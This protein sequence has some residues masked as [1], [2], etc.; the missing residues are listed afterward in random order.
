[1]SRTTKNLADARQLYSE[2]MAAHSK[3]G[4]PRLQRIFEAV[5]REAF[6]PPGPWHIVVNGKSVQTPSD[7]PALLYQNVLVA[8]DRN[9]GINNGE[10]FLHAAWLGAVAPASGDIVTHIGAGTGYYSAILAM[11]VLPGGTIEAFEIEDHLAKIARQNLTP[12]DNVTVRHADA[13]VARLQPSDLIYVNAGVV[14]PPASWLHALRQSGRLIFPW[15]PT[16][17]VGLTLLASR[18]EAGF[19]VRPLMRSWFIPC[20]GAGKEMEPLKDPDA[21]EARA[22]RSI[23]LTAERQPDE[24]AL[25]VY[26][27][28]WFSSVP[29]DTKDGL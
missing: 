13:S 25:A 9:K 2:L 14:A 5:P 7:D 18:S 22:V 26:R 4:D 19:A 16:D 8:L 12:F 29:L 1:M 28:V 27:D 10:P 24:T 21:R 20:V 17:T 11:L 3:S 15:R 6:L 23:W